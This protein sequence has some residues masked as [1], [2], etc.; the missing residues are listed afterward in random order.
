MKCREVLVAGVNGKEKRE[1]AW[2]S[3]QGTD[4]TKSPALL[5]N[6]LGV[7]EVFEL[8]REIMPHDEA[9]FVWLVEN[10]LEVSRL[11]QVS[12]LEMMAVMWEKADEGVF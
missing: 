4:Y 7:I 5:R 2:S 11:G 8:C 1:S 12:N 10:G 3:W 9:Y 6:K